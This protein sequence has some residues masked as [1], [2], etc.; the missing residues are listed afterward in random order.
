M[1]MLLLPE[2]F[3]ADLGTCPGAVLA[4]GNGDSTSG[5]SRLYFHGGG[6]LGF[7]VA[8]PARQQTR[9][10]LWIGRLYDRLQSGTVAIDWREHLSASCDYQDKLVRFLENHD[11]P[12]AASVFPWPRHRAA[13]AITFLSPGLRFFYEGQFEGARVPASR[14]SSAWASG[15]MDHEILEF[16]VK[17][18]AILNKAEDFRDGKWSQIEPKPAWSGNQSS[19]GSIATP[20]PVTMSVCMLSR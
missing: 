16:I 20:G 18:W 6:V 12:R 3:R 7:G 13:A 10:L 14:A 17:S 11:E 19:D 2:V 5:T 4:K 1:A 15:A 8:G 9:I